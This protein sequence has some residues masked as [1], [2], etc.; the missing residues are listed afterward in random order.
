MRDPDPDRLLPFTRGCPVPSTVSVKLCSLTRTLSPA[1]EPKSFSHSRFNALCSSWCFWTAHRPATSSRPRH[2]LLSETPRPTASQTP[3]A[4]PTEYSHDRHLRFCLHD[5]FP[6]IHHHISSGAPRLACPGC[7]SSST[8]R[9]ERD[10]DPAHNSF[11]LL[12]L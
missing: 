7:S 5:T 2:S 4:Q 8:A 1:L 9:C 11:P 6:S 12:S 10:P 3:K